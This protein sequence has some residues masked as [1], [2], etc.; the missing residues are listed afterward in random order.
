[1]DLKKLNKS[2][3]KKM[4]KSPAEEG[5]DYATIQAQLDRAQSNLQT[6]SLQLAGSKGIVKSLDRD[7]DV[8][9]SSIKDAISKLD[10]LI[11]K[12]Q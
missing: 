12:V 8:V 2:V 4:A 11:R 10:A 3:E 9:R 7:I 1:M 6:V 5:E